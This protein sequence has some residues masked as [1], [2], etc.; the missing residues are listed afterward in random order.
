MKTTT[1]KLSKI[2]AVV[3]LGLATSAAQ[4]GFKINITDEDTIEFG[5]Y[6]K[7]DARYVDGDV[8]YRDFWIGT[9]GAAEDTSAFNMNVRKRGSYQVYPRRR[10]GLHRDGFLWGWW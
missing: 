1:R 8:A 5:G 2:A 6:I 3:A 10:H 7:A 4:A 9:A